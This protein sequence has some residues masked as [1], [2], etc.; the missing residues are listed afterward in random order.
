VNT[1]QS[2]DERAS[3]F[4]IVL[5]ILFTCTI[6]LLLSQFAGTGIW[7]PHPN[8]VR[9]NTNNVPFLPAIPVSPSQMRQL[10]V[11]DIV[12]D[13]FEGLVPAGIVIGVFE[14]LVKGRRTKP[15]K[16]ESLWLAIG[17]LW[18]LGYLHRIITMKG[19]LSLGPIMA[20]PY[21][22]GAVVSLIVIPS[23]A[24]SR[25]FFARKDV[26]PLTDRLGSLV[27]LFQ[28]GLNLALIVYY[29]DIYS[30]IP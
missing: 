11:R 15:T 28:L 24:V 5:L 2:K 13:F 17:V 22:I 9:P 3:A 29:P 26:S 12:L 20:I 19:V 23:L 7:L 27:C 1:S 21:L 6:T 25:L 4:Q 30:P 14:I 10:L 18:A 16:G 8:T